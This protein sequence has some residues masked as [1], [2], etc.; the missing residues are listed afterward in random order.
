MRQEHERF[1]GRRGS[2]SGHWDCRR[3]G[4]CS[5]RNYGK[6]GQETDRPLRPSLGLTP[7]VATKTA[8]IARQSPCIEVGEGE[9]ER[10]KEGGLTSDLR[11]GAHM[12][13]VSDIMVGRV[14]CQRVFTLL[15]RGGGATANRSKLASSPTSRHG[16]PPSA[17]GVRG[18]N[19]C[20]PLIRH[21]ALFGVSPGLE[22]NPERPGLL[23][24]RR[25]VNG[26]VA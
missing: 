13:S 11:S 15:R 17:A 9:R 14:G 21:S 18:M 20:A 10:G 1:R 3:R 6:H 5:R 22:W 2:S 16:R 24:W 19:A 7:R 25:R 8:R 12:D 23:A 4:E 26:G